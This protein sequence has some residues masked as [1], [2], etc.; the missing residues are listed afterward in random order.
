MTLSDP[1]SNPDRTL[2]CDAPHKNPPEALQTVH[3]LTIT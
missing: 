3:R 2:A 1:E